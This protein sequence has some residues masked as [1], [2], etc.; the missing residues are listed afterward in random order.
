MYPPRSWMTFV[1]AVVSL[2]AIVTVAVRMPRTPVLPM[3]STSSGTD[4]PGA[5]SSGSVGGVDQLELRRLRAAEGQRGDAQILGAGVRD[6]S[7]SPSR[8]CGR[9]ASHRRWF[10]C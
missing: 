8:R 3:N 2:E 7:A 9:A 10:R 6:G 5:I 1:A 4:A